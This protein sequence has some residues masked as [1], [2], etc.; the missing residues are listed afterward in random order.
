M[1]ILSTIFDFTFSVIFQ[2]FELLSFDIFGDISLLDLHIG[3]M[4]I[5]LI[6]YFIKLSDP[7]LTPS[8]GNSKKQGTSKDISNSDRENDIASTYGNS[9]IWW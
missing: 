2:I 8:S 9:D 5:Y 7:Q 3:Y 6:I 1:E 4:I